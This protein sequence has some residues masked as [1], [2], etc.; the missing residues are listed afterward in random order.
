MADDEFK[1]NLFK[2]RK[3]RHDRP[4]F[5]FFLL[6]KKKPRSPSTQNKYGVLLPSVFFSTRPQMS[7]KAV[8]FPSFPPVNA[9]VVVFSVMRNVHPPLLIIKDSS[10]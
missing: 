9:N 6:S 8:S 3:E 10:A 1:L 4:S 5:V 2:F 7:L